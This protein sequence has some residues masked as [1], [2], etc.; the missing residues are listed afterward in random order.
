M[1]Y[2]IETPGQYLGKA[3]KIAQDHDGSIVTEEESYKALVDPDLAVIVVV[4]NGAFEAAAFTY[5]KKKWLDFHTDGD[6]RP[7]K[8]VIL[9]RDKAKELT[10]YDGD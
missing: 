9:N 8:Y 6:T 10:G 1:G 3:L 5:N 4:S 7:K 2:Y